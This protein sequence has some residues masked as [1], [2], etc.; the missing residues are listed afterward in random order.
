MRTLVE[1]N[2]TQLLL[3]A[4]QCCVFTHAALHNTWSDASQVAASFIVTQFIFTASEKKISERVDA[5]GDR[6][7]AITVT[8]H[9]IVIER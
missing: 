7:M 3:I 5:A 9:F 8:Q 1:S 4:L 2:F 6:C